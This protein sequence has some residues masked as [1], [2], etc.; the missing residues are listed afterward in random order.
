MKKIFILFVL[1]G[2]LFAFS[3]S[4]DLYTL[5]KGDFLGFNALFDED[6]NLYG[7]VSIYGYGKSGDKTKKFEYVLLDK[8][9]NP[10]ANKEFEGDI[11]ASDYF[12]YIDFRKKV[13]LFPSPDYY[14]IKTKDFFYPRSIEIDMATNTTKNKI[15]YDY[16]HGKFTEVAQ[17]ENVKES[18]KED[19]TERKENGFI[20]RSSVYEIKEGG[21]LVTEYDEYKTYVSNNSLIKFDENRNE[22]WRYRYNAGGTKKNYETLKIIDKNEKY[23]YGILQKTDNKDKNFNLLVLDMQTGAV[24]HNKEITGQSQKTLEYILYYYSY[25]QS[26][27]N[28]KVFDDK[29]VVVG[30][31]YDKNNAVGFARMIIDKSNFD[32]EIKN[33][34]YSTDFKILLPS[35]FINDRFSDGYEL[36]TKDFFFLE[37]GSVGILMEKYMPAGQYNA[38][39]TKDLYYAFTDKEFN[40][41]EVK[42]FEKEKTKWDNNDYLF[43]QYLNN[44]KDVVFFFRDLQKDKETREKN[45]K[46]FINTLINGN[47]KQEVV[48]ISEK[49]KYTTIPYV[50]KEGY[51]LLR[52]FNEKDKFNKIRLERL[53]Y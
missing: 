5:A 14:A 41:K 21:F 31:S 15:Y 20:Y 37:D 6:E 18:R 1:L 29:I 24:V 35:L 12:G 50:A 4:Q 33:I 22:I 26:L 7:Y 42:T 52:E 2:N 53:N 27:D 32:V 9:L 10:V 47:F 46:L 30:R 40:L 48:Q 13:M 3:Q 39:K 8:N 11:T 34:L 44:G 36:R 17:P 23:I 16:D 51:I 28:D 38:S 25:G 49:D 43:S 45:W 19:T